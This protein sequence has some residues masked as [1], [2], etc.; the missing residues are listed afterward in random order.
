MSSG[1]STSP[2]MSNDFCWLGV[3]ETAARIRRREISPVEVTR[4]LLQRIERHDGM[5]NAF[6]TRAD[7]VALTAAR[8]A[9][10]AMLAED[11]LGP[12]YGVPFALKD[13]IDA[14]GLPTTCHSR[15]LLDNV[16]GADAEVTRKLSDA[17]AILMG[18]LATHEFALGGPSFDLPWPPAR[19]PWNP[20]MS[21]GGSSSGAGAAVAAGFVSL[22]IGSDTGGS[23]RNPASMCGI[24]G[25]KPTY[26][27]VSRRGVF[28]LSVSLDHVGP[29]TRSVADNALVLNVTAGHDRRDPGSTDRP[30]PDFTAGIGHDIAAMRIGVIRHFHCRDLVADGDVND[31]IERALKILQDLGAEIVEVETA[32]LDAFAACNRIIMLT[33]A[34]AVHETWLRDRPED[35]GRLTR[36]RLLP[37]LFLSGVDYVQ[38]LRWR[39]QLAADMDRVLMTV[40]VAVTATNMEPAFPI[41]DPDAVETFYPR[42]ARTP[43]NVTGHPALSLPIGLSAAGLPLGMQIVGHHWD[44][45]TVYR[46]AHA[47]EQATSW[48]TMRPSLTN[49]TDA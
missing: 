10:A 43:F 35:Y 38:A 46:V 47:Y 36:E 3:G 1:L 23:V 20:R 34:G 29:L 6:I 21:P 18:K 19:N 11:R 49:G 12:L 44:E 5:L 40:D 26:G 27:R 9:E 8:R 24:V 28:P 22:A 45:A 42:H 4:G 16:A 13:I 7:E 31:A 17:G 25:M 32:P 2:K 48:H 39:R 37:G 14:T 15:I 33:E 30:V 41:D